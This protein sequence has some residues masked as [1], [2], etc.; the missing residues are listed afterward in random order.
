MEEKKEEKKMTK[1]QVYNVIILDRSGS[2]G[3]IRRAAIDGFNET[4]AGIQKA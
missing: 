2:M 3:S 4:L 1:T